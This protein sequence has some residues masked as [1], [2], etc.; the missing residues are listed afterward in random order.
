MVL[1]DKLKDD[2]MKL[3]KEILRKTVRG[4]KKKKIVEKRFCPI[5]GS[6]RL[7]KLKNGKYKC[8]LCKAYIPKSKLKKTKIELRRTPRYIG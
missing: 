5:C 7:R 2:N 6:D 8:L 1:I 4:A 3:K